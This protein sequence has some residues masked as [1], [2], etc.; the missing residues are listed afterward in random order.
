MRIMQLVSGMGV[1]GAVLQCWT[2]AR[3]LAARGHEITLVCRPNSWSSIQPVDRGM[4]L[5]CNDLRRWPFDDLHAIARLVAR[6]D[7]DVIH[8]HQ[9]RAHFFGI[10][11]RW[12]SQ[13]PCVATAHSRHLQPFW[14]FNDY[15][16]AN[17]QATYRF[18]RTWNL[19]RTDRMEVVNYLVNL[20]GF[21]KASAGDR[22]RLRGTWGLTEYERVAGI[23]GD[24]IPR[25][26]H[27]HVVRAW[28]HI[29]QRL[30]SARLVIIGE[31]KDRA[32]AQL[33]REES[34]RL[35]V[36]K[37][38]IWAGYRTDIPGVMQAIDICVSAALEEAL[39]LTVPEA[40]AACRPVVATNVGGIPENIAD[41]QTGLLV[42]PADPKALAEAVIRL[43]SDEQWRHECGQR[44]CKHVREKYNWQRQLDQ[45][46]S[47]YERTIDRR[48]G[49]FSIPFPTQMRETAPLKRRAA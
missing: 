20:D 44:A 5:I 32:Y 30:P 1:N 3:A 31:E 33:L 4:T 8:T 6:E 48:R 28:P 41:G 2:L 10:L 14:R 42:P 12:M 17:S 29:V 18:Q 35:G 34:V 26:G 27:L 47:V 36:D 40:M 37:Y 39:G 19:V 46:E 13:V 11:L 22:Q 49:R 23:V 21:A 43:L 9:S 16:I 7:I 24:V 45:V 25:K 15:V 38:I